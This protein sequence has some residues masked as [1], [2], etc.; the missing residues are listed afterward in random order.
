MTEP[1]VAF[2]YV[3]PYLLPF[4]RVKAEGP[5]CS[6]LQGAALMFALV[7]TVLVFCMIVGFS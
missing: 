5:C 7:R 3:D 2:F 1:S 6:I 4:L